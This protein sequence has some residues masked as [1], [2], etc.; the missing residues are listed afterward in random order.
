MKNK[1]KAEAGKGTEVGVEVSCL[2]YEQKLRK[3]R[4]A[5]DS[6]V[7]ARER[8]ATLNVNSGYCSE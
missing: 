4:M 7:V 5:G 8:P 1:I 3:V 6:C 2:F